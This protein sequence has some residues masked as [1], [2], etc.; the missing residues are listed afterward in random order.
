L[1]ICPQPSGCHT[2][3]VHIRD[4]NS[5]L[6]REQ[7]RDVTLN[8]EDLMRE[9]LKTLI[10]DTSRQIPL[11]DSAIREADPQRCA[12]L[13]HYSKGACANVG[14]TAAA[15]VLKALEYQAVRREFGQCRESLGALI[16]QMD[17][18]RLE[19]SNPPSAAL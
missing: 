10:D 15:E 4:A 1:R 12:R 7:L 9:I 3:S 6:D 5:V 11:L 8:D 17:L 2:R 18:L 13:A 16:H 14:A 19:A